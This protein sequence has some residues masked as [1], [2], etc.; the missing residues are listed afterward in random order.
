MFLTKDYRLKIWFESKKSSVKLSMYPVPNIKWNIAWPRPWLVMMLALLVVVAT[1]MLP[2]SPHHS[3]RNLAE[4]V[5]S[6]AKVGGLENQIGTTRNAVWKQNK[7]QIQMW[8]APRSLAGWFSEQSDLKKPKMIC[9]HQR[10]LEPWKCRQMTRKLNGSTTPSAQCSRSQQKIQSM[11]DSC[12]DFCE[13]VC[14][15][16]F[17]ALK[18]EVSWVWKF[19]ASGHL[20][21]QQWGWKEKNR[22][23]DVLRS[24]SLSCDYILYSACQ[25]TLGSGTYC[26]H[27][28]VYHTHH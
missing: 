18:S 17:C 4:R 7:T 15:S 1:L 24:H 27:M 6:Q 19:W 10:P 2:K 23:D 28:Q 3:H 25:Y 8:L 12:H 9:L 20:N 11:I 13:E 22:W 14:W 21:P 26:A 5:G 16:V